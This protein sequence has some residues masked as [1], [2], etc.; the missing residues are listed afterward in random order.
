MAQAMIMLKPNQDYFKIGG[1]CEVTDSANMGWAGIDESISQDTNYWVEV[2]R[3]SATTFTIKAF[4]NSNYSSNQVGSTG[5]FTVSSGAL[6]GVRYIHFE[7]HA[8][9]VSY[10]SYGGGILTDLEFWGTTAVDEKATLFG[11]DTSATA[12]LTSTFT[13]SA[14]GTTS[15]CGGWNFRRNNSNST[16][17]QMHV[18]L[19][20]SGSTYLSVYDLVTNGIISSPISTES[21]VLRFSFTPRSNSWDS[22]ASRNLWVGL[23]D[24]G[25]TGDSDGANNSQDFVGMEKIIKK[26]IHD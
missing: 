24:N 7:E 23:T 16:T 10:D 19:K 15:N 13:C 3:T 1:R 22:G 5:T 26:Y 2:R 17:D 20:R 4:T 25:G 12:D 14:S 8:Q 21:F 18:T 6:D 11:V 9:N